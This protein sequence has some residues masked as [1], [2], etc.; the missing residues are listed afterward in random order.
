[1]NYITSDTAIIESE[2]IVNISDDGEL[3]F[4]EERIT[5][6]ILYKM[7]EMHKKGASKKGE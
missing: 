2:A 4:D 7:I 1:M 5:E 6:K 3:I